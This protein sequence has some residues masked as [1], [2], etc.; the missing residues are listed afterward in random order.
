MVTQKAKYIEQAV[1]SRVG[2]NAFPFRIAHLVST[3]LRRHLMSGAGGSHTG[4]QERDTPESKQKGPGA[5]GQRGEGGSA[6]RT[7]RLYVGNGQDRNR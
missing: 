7:M 3:S 2:N 5:G 6:T 1:V 4:T